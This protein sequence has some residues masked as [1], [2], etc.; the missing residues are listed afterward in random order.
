[1][2]RVFGCNIQIRRPADC[3]TFL[4]SAPFESHLHACWG[5]RLVPCFSW[6]SLSTTST[7]PHHLSWEGFFGDLSIGQS[8]KKRLTCMFSFVFF[9]ANLPQ[10]GTRPGIQRLR[11][12]GD[13]D[14]S[15]GQ[16]VGNITGLA[17]L[18]RA[19]RN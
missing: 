15:A 16:K 17:G 10:R 19:K 14:P 13:S 18:S 1:M 12:P 5:T 6:G 11:I 8:F 4:W 7:S 2:T 9:L 3:A